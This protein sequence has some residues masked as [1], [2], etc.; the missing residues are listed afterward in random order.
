VSVVATEVRIAV[1]GCAGAPRALGEHG[2]T[3]YVAID[4]GPG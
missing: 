3:R 4:H 1:I 2:E